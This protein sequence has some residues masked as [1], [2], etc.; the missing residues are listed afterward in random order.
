MNKAIEGSGFATTSPSSF[1]STQC[2]FSNN[3]VSGFICLNLGSD[4]WTMSISYANIVHNNSLSYG[5]MNTE[6]AGT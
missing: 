2:T 6:G 4:S 5:V 1:T 3:L